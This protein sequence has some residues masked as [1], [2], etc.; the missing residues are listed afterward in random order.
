MLIVSSTT[1]SFR[2]PEERDAIELFN[3]THDMNKWKVSHFTGLMN[4]SIS[5][6]LYFPEKRREVYEDVEGQTEKEAAC[7]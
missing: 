7:Y 6:T 4:Y 2:D 1:I 3:R 5:E